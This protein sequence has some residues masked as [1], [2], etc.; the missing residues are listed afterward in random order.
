M[1]DKPLSGVDSL[2]GASAKNV[3]AGVGQSPS[4]QSTPQQ[5]NGNDADWDEPEP[6]PLPVP[7][8]ENEAS[9]SAHS[10]TEIVERALFHGT[11]I[12]TREAITS[13]CEEWSVHVLLGLITECQ[14]LRK[15]LEEIKL[16]MGK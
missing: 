12:T 10:L 5:K 1:S 14:Q 3:T 16:F 2:A 4:A 13:A 6:P 7:Q 15:Q 8:T 11:D 9:P